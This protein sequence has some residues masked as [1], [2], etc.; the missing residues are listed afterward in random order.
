MQSWGV[1]SVHHLATPLLLRHK[2]QQ[3]VQQAEYYIWTLTKFFFSLPLSDLS[4]VS[5]LMPFH[6]STPTPLLAILLVVNTPRQHIA[7]YIFHL[8]GFPP[9]SPSSY[10]FDDDGGRKDLG[11]REGDLEAT[12]PE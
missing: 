6:P 12:W 2:L 11:M 5:F 3:G 4:P 8:A 7:L 9:N 1:L 10:F